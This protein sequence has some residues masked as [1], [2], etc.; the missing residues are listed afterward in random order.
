[1]EVQYSLREKRKNEKFQRRLK[2]EKEK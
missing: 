2:D 1:M